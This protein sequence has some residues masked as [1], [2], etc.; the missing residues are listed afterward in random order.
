MIESLL[1]VA[2]L[3]AFYWYLTAKGFFNT[4]GS[5]IVP[6]D[7]LDAQTSAGCA[8]AKIYVPEDAVLRRHFMTHLRAEIEAGLSPRPA[9]SIL[10][11]HH[12]AM[13]AA[14]L[15]QRLLEVGRLRAC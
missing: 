13:V 9:D 6:A 8:K 10:Q 7:T 14:K 11:R 3:Y 2:A 4:A 1:A 15:E 5:E 12:E